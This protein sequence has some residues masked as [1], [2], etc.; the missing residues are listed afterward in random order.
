MYSS[1]FCDLFIIPLLFSCCCIYFCFFIT[2][3][4][5]SSCFSL[6]SFAAFSVSRLFSFAFILLLKIEHISAFFCCYCTFGCLS[7]HCTYAI[8]A[9]FN[10]FIRFAVVFTLFFS[11][12]EFGLCACIYCAFTDWTVDMKKKKTTEYPILW[13]LYRDTTKSNRLTHLV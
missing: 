6:C 13:Y 10:L 1:R 7:L 8:Q 9:I 4:H 11:K 2:L 5:Y 12:Y 3:S